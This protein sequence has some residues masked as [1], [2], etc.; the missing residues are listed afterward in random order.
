MHRIGSAPWD[1][2]ASDVDMLITFAFVFA[3]GAIYTKMVIPSTVN[4]DQA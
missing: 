3:G 1:V 2:E 4:Q